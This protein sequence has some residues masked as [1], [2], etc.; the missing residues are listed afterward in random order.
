MF[1]ITNN[2]LQLINDRIMYN[3][4]YFLTAMTQQRVV[5]VAFIVAFVALVSLSS[6]YA[7]GPD[8]CPNVYNLYQTDTDQD[9]IGNHCD[10][11]PGI[12]G[13]EV[14]FNLMDQFGGGGIA[15]GYQ[16]IY[17]YGTTTSKGTS[18]LKADG[19]VSYLIAKP[20]RVEIVQNA[21]QTGCTGLAAASG[22]PEY[23]KVL[24]LNMVN[25]CNVLP[26]P[27]YDPDRDGK[28]SATNEPPKALF[29]FKWVDNGFEQLAQG[30]N[31]EVFDASQSASPFVRSYT[32]DFGDGT[33]GTGMYI[34][35]TFQ[36]AKPYQVTLT[37]TDQIG[38]K[39]STTKTVMVNPT[40]AYA[41][42][43]YLH[44]EEK[45]F[46]MDPGDFIASSKLKWAHN[47]CTDDD[48]RAWS[49]LNVLALKQGQYTHQADFLSCLGKA[50]GHFGENYSSNQLTAPA[51]AIKAGESNQL[52][53]TPGR[54]EGFYLDIPKNKQLG[55]KPTRNQPYTNN[56]YYEYVQGKYIIYW[57]FYG[58]SGR[59]LDE[60]EGD[61]E[62]IVVRL[63]EKDEA[64]HVT[65][66]QHFCDPANADYGIFT[67]EEM[68][69]KN[70]LWG[71]HP[72][73]FSALEG[74]PS[75][76]PMNQTVEFP[77]GDPLTIRQ[78]T[79]DRVNADFTDISRAWHTANGTLRDAR[80]Q[81]WYGLGVGWGERV[82]VTDLGFGWGPL[83]PGPLKLNGSVP[84][85][86]LE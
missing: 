10:E 49:P 63:N 52:H 47:D 14:R 73:V 43:L 40:R 27:D 31:T 51:E 65:Y 32:W 9:G 50:V 30:A 33:T 11:S 72:A 37:V 34:T 57:F 18:P 80:K 23:G 26:P 39:A 28:F 29:T 45:H 66:Y 68:R 25:N 24:V 20:D 1:T 59:D 5:K 86:W 12:S 35:H 58:Y 3:F 42:I 48:D 17:Y 78:G 2:N 69:Q 83:G 54:R 55:D 67:W 19:G 16:I 60:H 4:K 79:F 15:G 7:Q 70:Y 84:S 77:C 41:P 71:S 6:T 74:H 76:P 56:L 62:H 82:S 36:E 21:W 22:V 46:P 8:N 61:W 81:P 38:Q 53:V 85:D 64:T 13:W 44:P 75:F